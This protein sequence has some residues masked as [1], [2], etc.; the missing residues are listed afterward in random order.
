MQMTS[1]LIFLPYWKAAKIF[2]L[3]YGKR[4]APASKACLVLLRPGLKGGKNNIILESRPKIAVMCE[5]KIEF[6]LL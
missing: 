6:K 1:L 5:A 2:I 3:S 4:F